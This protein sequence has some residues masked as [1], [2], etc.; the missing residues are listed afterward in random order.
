MDAAVI[1]PFLAASIELFQ[2]MFRIEATP[3]APYVMGKEIAHRWEISGILGVTGDYQGVVAVR[4]SRILANKMLEKSGIITSSDEERE[5]TL[6]G[7][8]GEL[9]NI[10]SGNASN[11]IQHTIDISPPI[12]VHGQNHSIA[13]PKTIPVIAIPFVTP[14]GPF[15]V[16]VCFKYRD[17]LKV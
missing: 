6:Y 17:L 9:V 15:E 10:I 13:W 7:M 5:E 1:N 11:R 3:S 8:I 14:L 4:L 2:T 12:V 16:A